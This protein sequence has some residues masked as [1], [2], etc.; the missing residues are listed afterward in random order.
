LASNSAGNA[1]HLAMV[2]STLAF[3]TFFIAFAALASAALDWDAFATY[4]SF[5]KLSQEH[6]ME[7]I[8]ERLSPMGTGTIPP[9]ES[10]VTVAID[11]AAGSGKTSTARAVAERFG[12]AF[13]ST[14]EHYRTLARLLIDCAIGPD[15]ANAVRRKV[16][17]LSPSTIF[18]GR[19]AHMAIDNKIPSE[20]SLRNGEINGA[21][22]NYAAI[23]EL[24][25]F[26]HRYQR[27]LPAA[28]MAAGFR[29][30]VL[31]GRDMTSTVFPDATVKVH[32]QADLAQREKRRAAEGVDDNI[33]ERDRLDSAQLGRAKGVWCIDGTNL[34]LDEVV[35]L[36]AKRIETAV[37]SD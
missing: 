1:Y 30:I 19:C 6:A 8:G 23:A 4:D 15:D 34:S 33:V 37:K 14:G 7:L 12:Y 9:R 5:A 10:F 26:L 11:G 21:V 36:I 24:R 2:R 22:C 16:M 25:N 27:Q 32:L 31:E 13:A 20:E 28:A 18:R 29:G 17:S 35:E 3:V